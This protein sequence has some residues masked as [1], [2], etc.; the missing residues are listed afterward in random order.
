MPNII[1]VI[2]YKG[3]DTPFSVF[4]CFKYILFMPMPVQPIIMRP[5]PIKQIKAIKIPI[6]AAKNGRINKNPTKSHPL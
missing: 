3:F 4:I 6:K 5:I 2:L 1:E